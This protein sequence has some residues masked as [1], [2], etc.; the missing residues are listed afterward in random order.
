MH[1][2]EATRKFSLRK[3]AQLWQLL[4]VVVKWVGQNTLR[5]VEHW[6]MAASL[7]R[8]QATTV[9]TTSMYIEQ[10]HIF[11]DSS[12]SFLGMCRSFCLVPVQVVVMG[13]GS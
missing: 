9:P 1:P 12:S 5:Q 2:I 7:Q 11:Y 13:I 6:L 8:V 3:F 4:D 10:Q